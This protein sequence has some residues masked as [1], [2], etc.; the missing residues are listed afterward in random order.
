MRKD[1]DLNFF[2]RT[3]YGCLINLRGDIQWR[4]PLGLQAVPGLILFLGMFLLP[5]SIRWLALK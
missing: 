1:T 5:E 2:F 4:L 3:N